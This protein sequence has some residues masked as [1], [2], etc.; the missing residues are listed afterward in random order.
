MPQKLIC[1]SQSEKMKK[2][3]I[4]VKFIIGDFGL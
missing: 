3:R 4:G 1:N 2:L